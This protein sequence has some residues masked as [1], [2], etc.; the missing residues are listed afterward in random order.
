MDYGPSDDTSLMIDTRMYLEDL[1]SITDPLE[2]LKDPLIVELKDLWWQMASADTTVDLYNNS[3]WCDVNDDPLVIVIHHMIA[4]HSI[5][6]QRLENHVQMAA[7]VAS[8]HVG[9]DRRS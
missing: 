3:N 7:H 5:H 2:I 8:T 6:Q 1:T 4:I 9:E